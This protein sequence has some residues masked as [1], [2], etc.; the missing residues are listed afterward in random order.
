MKKK[1]AKT[2]TITATGDEK[3][4]KMRLQITHLV[5]ELML[6][7]G[8]T[9]HDLAKRSGKPLKAVQ[10]FL[11]GHGDLDMREISDVFSHLGQKL[12]VELV[13]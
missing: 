3:L 10:A 4:S 13:R 12:R 9:H 1:P 6:E 5:C 7:Q 2:R 11:G 8:L